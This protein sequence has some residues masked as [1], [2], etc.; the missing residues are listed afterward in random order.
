MTEKGIQGQLYVH[1]PFIPAVL[2]L[3]SGIICGT[4]LHFPRIIVSVILTAC[5]FATLKRIYEKKP[6]L[7]PVLF[8]CTL[9][10]ILT[11]Q[12]Y[13]PPAFPDHHI[14][15]FTDY[16]Y[17]KITGIVDSK[18]FTR[19]NRT[20][21]HLQVN[22][23]EKDN[24]VVPVTGKIRVSI[25]GEMEQLQKGVT[26]SFPGKI[27]SIKNFGNPGGFDYRRYMAFQQIH[28]LTY[29]QGEK[30]KIL[31]PKTEFHF[32]NIL[33]KIRDP[34]S[35]F[36]YE[37]KGGANAKSILS[38]LIIGDK[39]NIPPSLREDFNRAGIGHLL[40]IS[41]LHIGIVASFAF[42]LFTF[43]LSFSNALLFH[44]W[45][46]KGAALL[47]I[48]P[49]LYYGCI[50]GMSPSTQRAIIMVTV[51]LLA[52]L[53]ERERDTLNTLAV[54]AFI[55]LAISPPA[56][57]T[58]SFQLSFSAVLSIIFGV[59]LINSLWETTEKG[60]WQHM[61]RKVFL[62]IMVS[63]F[64]IL[65]TLPFTLYYFNQVA[66]SGIITNMIFIPLIGFLVVPTAL[67]A[68]FIMPIF[69][70]GSKWLLSICIYLLEKGEKIIVFISDLPFSSATT[71]T[72]NIIETVCYYTLFCATLL[73]IK[74][75]RKIIPTEEKKKKYDSLLITLTA[76]II[77]FIFLSIDIFY[78]IHERFFN[79]S[80]KITAIDV[81]Q[82]AST[83]IELPKGG[84]LLI[85]GG[86][87]S[88]NAVFDVGKNIVAP[89][90]LRKKIKT[91]DMV[92]LTHPESDHLNGLIH[93]IEHLHVK[94][95]LSNNCQT[96]RLGFKK[97][98]EALDK[99]NIVLEDYKKI[100]KKLNI[101]DVDINILYP[102]SEFKEKSLVEKWRNSNNNS[103]VLKLTFNRVS[104]LFPGDIMKKAEKELV[105]ISGNSLKS[106]LL[107]A[108]H[109]GSKSSS[110]QLFLDHV[111]PE[112]IIISAGWGNRYHMPHKEVLRKYQLLPSKI[113]R[114]DL[115][116]AIEIITDGETYTIHPFQL[117]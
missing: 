71:V 32:E 45:V 98:C 83:L 91:I 102:A 51:F 117:K 30:I 103:I 38:A 70:I 11:I 64:A 52:F 3:I 114:T 77:A 75:H 65:G 41:G 105:Q 23:L 44:A 72:P 86:G 34:I 101:N 67:A 36:I 97:F 37:Q 76:L 56:L 62:F 92:I 89:L 93:I 12:A 106:N 8:A 87:F 10:G 96:H 42:F 80:M 100:E 82:G 55:I 2:A 84:I 99:K 48:I 85:D 60:I 47:S 14:T 4:K 5:I 79:K 40:A 53:V 39:S 6:L 61:Y 18:P 31:S 113:F 13:L 107:F 110:S 111:N 78:Q 49:I 27:K 95:I 46:K 88:D 57:L 104:I 20:R 66:F 24:Q 1:R 33:D 108:P 17:Y 7:P 19:N 35:H 9:Y 50:S 112:A 69:P 63:V 43:I 26:I 109:H 16:H 68:V 94:K 29:T 28:G 54:S 90:L 22:T 21:F 73:L 116:G 15:D 58:I 59:S 115:Q 81:G 25:M 74:N